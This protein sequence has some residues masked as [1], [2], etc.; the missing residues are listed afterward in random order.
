MAIK[1]LLKSTSGWLYLN[2]SVG[3]NQLQGAGVILMLHRVL[4]S[5][6]AADL[7]HR[8]ELCVGPKAFEHLLGWLKKHFDCVS[9]MEILQPGKVRSDR[10]KITLTFDDGW[11]DNAVN[12]FPLLQKYQVPASIFLSTDFIGSRQRFWWESI[13]E[14]L[15]GSHGERA[16]KQLIDCLQQIGRPLPVPFDE[17]DVERR[18]LVLLH[19]LQSLKTLSPQDLNRLTDECPDESLPQALD[20]HQVRSLEASGLVRF[21]PHGASHAILT[22]LDDQHLHEELSRSR[23]ALLNGCNRPLPVYCYPNGDNDARVREQVAEHDFPFALGTGTGIYRR[24]C[25]PLNLPRFGV[26]QRAAR[27][28]QLLSWRLY[29]GA[30]A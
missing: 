28:P 7:P 14:T 12:A 9:L 18:S 17:L 6:D 11:R 16:R 21:G 8:N 23:D 15:W 2:S 25:D 29:R 20:W 24:N 4:A 27:N 5:D 10:P 19:F 22:G 3:R 1:Q 13:G 30:R 26:S